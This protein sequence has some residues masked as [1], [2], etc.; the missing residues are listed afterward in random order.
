MQQAIDFTININSLTVYKEKV[1]PTL[2]GRKL[3]VLEA[4]RELK[5]A[6]C[7]EVAAYLSA[8]KGYVVSP[9]I[10]SGRFGELLKLEEIKSVGKKDVNGSPHEIWIIA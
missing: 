9:N 10:I 1:I 4:I 8:K 7:Y 2:R 3:E 5:Q 6:T